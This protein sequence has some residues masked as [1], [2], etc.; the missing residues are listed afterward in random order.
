MTYFFYMWDE[1]STQVQ[2]FEQSWNKYLVI[3]IPLKEKKIN[4]ANDAL[5]RWIHNSAILHAI[6][7]PFIWS[8]MSR[9][10]LLDIALP[11][12]KIS[13]VFAA[14]ELLENIVRHFWVE[15]VIEFVIRNFILRIFYVKMSI[16]L[17][18]CS[19]IYI[20]GNTSNK[21]SGSLW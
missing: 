12:A 21:L 15:F 13:S 18:T 14:G 7:C 3:N 20:K 4:S 17:Y 9:G 11:K 2:Q 6:S 5:N 8:I 10:I 1:K 19:V 16:I